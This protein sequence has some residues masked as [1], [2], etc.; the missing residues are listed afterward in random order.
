MLLGVPQKIE[1]GELVVAFDQEYGETALAAVCGEIRYLMKKL[2]EISPLSE[3]RF[4]RLPGIRAFTG[5]ARE[6]ALDELKKEVAPNETVKMASALFDGT[7]VDVL[8]D[9]K[10]E[11]S[12]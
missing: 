4:L 8:E 9:T 12:N 3:F 5:A 7:V 6:K 2:S 10:D 11:R 1:N